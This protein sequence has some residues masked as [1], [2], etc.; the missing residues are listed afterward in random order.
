MAQAEIYAQLRD[1]VRK[2]RIDHRNT[3]EHFMGERDDI[4]NE[5]HRLFLE[6]TRQSAAP[7]RRATPLDRSLERAVRGRIGP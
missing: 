7:V 1:R 3:V 4:G 5:L 2:L 6:A